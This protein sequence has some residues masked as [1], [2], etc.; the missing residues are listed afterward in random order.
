M[1]VHFGEENVH[2]MALSHTSA[3]AG[4]SLRASLYSADTHAGG[5]FTGGFAFF[6]GKG[7][8]GLRM[9]LHMQFSVGY[10]HSSKHIR[11]E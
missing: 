6:E 1:V 5:T 3:E 9:R 2:F 8:T 10:E 11:V 4:A 7:L